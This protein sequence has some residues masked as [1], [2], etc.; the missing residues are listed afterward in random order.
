MIGFPATMAIVKRWGGIPLHIPSHP[1][2]EHAISQQA[3]LEAAHKLAGQY[4][5]DTLDVARGVGALRCMR[6]REIV[7][8]Y[9]DGMSASK[10]ARRFGLSRRQIFNILGTPLPEERD[11]AQLQLPFQ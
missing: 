1:G 3:G 4:G 11:P 2:P 9:D 5:G 6:N 8:L 7:Q 10:I